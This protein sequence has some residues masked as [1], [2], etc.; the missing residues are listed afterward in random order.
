MATVAAQRNTQRNT[1]RNVEAA[2]NAAQQNLKGGSSLVAAG[3]REVHVHHVHLNSTRTSSVPKVGEYAGRVAGAVFDQNVEAWQ[4]WAIEVDGMCIELSR[5]HDWEKYTKPK[6]FIRD[7]LTADEWRK[8]RSNER[9]SISTVSRGYTRKSLQ[10]IKNA[11][12]RIWAEWQAEY[13]PNAYSLTSR[14]CQ[15]FADRLL[16]EILEISDDAASIATTQ[17]TRFSKAFDEVGDDV[18][19]FVGRGIRKVLG[20][21][22]FKGELE[23]EFTH[24]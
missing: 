15:D 19:Q 24:S 3:L 2:V 10:D 4:H 13:G 20:I 22:G 7:Y 8:G 14:N 5:R 18:V 12:H 17:T 23:F 1:Q 11:A 16:E 6:Y 21:A 9:L